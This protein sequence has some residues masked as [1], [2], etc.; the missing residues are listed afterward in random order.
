MASSF[1]RL[2]KDRGIWGRDGIQRLQKKKRSAA[3]FHSA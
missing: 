1:R 3:A 2:V